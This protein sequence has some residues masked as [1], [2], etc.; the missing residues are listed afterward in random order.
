MAEERRANNYP[1][2]EVVGG[3]EIQQGDI[4][5]KCPVINPPFEQVMGGGEAEMQVV[6]QS[7]IILSQSC[8][9]ARR[10]DAPPKVD[11]VIFCPFYYRDELKRDKHFG[12]PSG[13]EDARTGKYPR[14]HILNACDLKDHKCD[15][16]AVDLSRVFS[17]SFKLVEELASS[18]GAR[19]RLNPPY[20][21][22]L[23][24]AY[25]RFF[26]RVGLPVDI[27]SFR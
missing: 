27:P 24:Q 1:W 7:A 11:Q 12:N 26:M 21:E 16:M 3:S 5:F 10:K 20:R 2:Y 23:S 17:L 25:A 4:L 9:L 22:H 6:Y 8:D 18:H 15:F 19:I 13:W 14:Y